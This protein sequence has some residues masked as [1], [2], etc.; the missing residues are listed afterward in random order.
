MARVRKGAKKAMKPAK[1][2]GGSVR[3]RGRTNDQ[4]IDAMTSGGI[5]SRA[6]KTKRLN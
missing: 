5:E 6:R 3:R 4:I 2:T 1:D